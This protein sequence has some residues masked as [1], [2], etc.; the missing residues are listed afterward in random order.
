MP[1]GR[2]SK[3]KISISQF[4]VGMALLLAGEKLYDTAREKVSSVRQSRWL[5]AGL[6]DE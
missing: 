1:S 2:P 4:L 6:L 3:L 5:Q